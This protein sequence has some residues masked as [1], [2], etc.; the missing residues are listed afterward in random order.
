[1]RCLWHGSLSS[2]TKWREALTVDS[3]FGCSDGRRQP[4]AR[5][6]PQK[7][8]DV[9]TCRTGGLDDQ[10]ADDVNRLRSMILA[11]RWKKSFNY[12]HKQKLTTTRCSGTRR[13]AR[14][15]TGL[16]MP[17]QFGTNWS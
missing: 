13:E 10:S 14:V 3:R 4:S 6:P 7:N 16:V 15:V 17:F 5:P 12:F 2:R 11:R 9:T 1:M 8:D